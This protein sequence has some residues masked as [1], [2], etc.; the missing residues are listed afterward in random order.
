M[1]PYVVACRALEQADVPF[2]VIGAYGVNLF[3][4]RM[5]R[6]ISTWDCDLLLP[7]DEAIL[8]RA[9]VAL[10]AN[11]FQFHA[12]GE[13]LPTP[14]PL[15][16]AGIVRAGASVRASLGAG[17]VDLVLSAAAL[18]FQELWPRRRRLLIAD[19]T[20]NVAPLEDLLRSKAELG[21]PKDKYFLEVWREILDEALQWE[22]Q[23]RA[24]ESPG[25]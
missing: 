19:V 14:D 4:T 23:R 25:C 2:L 22:Q 5:G 11:G 15:I 8:Q 17:E 7:R 10:G 18:D 20:V 21:R 6:K 12:G 3:I 13:P 1:D 16:L 24:R 9:L